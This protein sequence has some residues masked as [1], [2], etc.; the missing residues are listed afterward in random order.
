MAGIFISYR[1]EDA[2]ASA[3]RLYDR[4]VARYGRRTVFRAVETLEPA[5]DFGEQIVDAIK[6]CDALLAVIGRDW[7]SI[8]DESGRPRILNPDDWVSLEIATALSTG[9]VVI[10]VRVE[11]A[12]MPSDEDGIPEA[13][14]RFP[15]IQAV[16]I[17]DDSFDHDFG[18][19][20]QVIEKNTDLRPGD[21]W[22]RVGYGLMIAGIAA[23]I[24]GGVQPIDPDAWF[25]SADLAAVTLVAVVLTLLS[26]GPRARLLAS[27]AVVAVG[28]ATILRYAQSLLGSALE[29]IDPTTVTLYWVG[30]VSG[31]LLTAGGVVTY[32][33]APK[34][35]FRLSG[36]QVAPAVLLGFIGITLIGTSIGLDNE[37]LFTILRTSM[38]AVVPVGLAVVSILALI[39]MLASPGFRPMGMGFLI[40]FGLQAVLRFA[41]DLDTAEVQAAVW[42]GL[43]GG[44][45]MLAGGLIAAVQLA[46]SRHGF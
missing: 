35:S 1:T 43:A 46:R 37:R 16:N 20:T 36:G 30:L 19:L 3:G 33:A 18:L 40:V 14:E 32:V 6:S 8:T 27:G 13:L 45:L 21:V 29:S 41:N 15:R 17:R 25:V 22:T 11:G 34:E 2:A 9:K 12:R 10:P 5:K 28:I 23:R 26:R 4:L 44:A 38:P 42:L 7:L 31:L 24:V 39:A